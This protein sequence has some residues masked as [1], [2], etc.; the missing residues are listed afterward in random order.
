VVPV[1][2]LP[3]LLPPVAPGVLLFSVPELPEPSSTLLLPFAP[4][5]VLFSVP[6]PPS[7]VP[8]PSVL[9]PVVPGVVLPSGALPFGLLSLV[10]SSVQL[11]S[12]P[13]PLQLTPG[14]VVIG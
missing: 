13:L 2:L 11:V 1:V 6:A 9:P 7:L 10:R 8:P 12:A 3:V 5:V 14:V 4:G